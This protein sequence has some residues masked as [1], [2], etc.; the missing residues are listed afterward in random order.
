[1]MALGPGAA[2]A[3]PRRSASAASSAAR[4]LKRR[5]V[6]VV[7]RNLPKRW[8][9]TAAWPL[10]HLRPHLEYPAATHAAQQHA[11]TRLPAGDAPEG[12]LRTM[13]RGPIDAEEEVTR[14]QSRML[15]RTAD[16]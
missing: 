9:S 3:S 7:M 4:E 15:R 11:G 2:M 8:A 10:P 16:V 14:L 1:M 13:R 6:S 12:V 5:V